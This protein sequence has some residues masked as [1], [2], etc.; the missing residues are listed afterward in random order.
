MKPR[1]LIFENNQI[2]RSTIREILDKR[3]YEVFTFTDADVCPLHHSIEHKCIFEGTCSDIIISDLYM[4]TIEGL[5]SIKEQIDNGCKVKCRALM[6]A[7]WSDEEWQFAQ[8]IGCRL[9]EKPFDV[10]EFLKWIDTCVSRV[11]PGR[12]LFNWSHKDV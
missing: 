12:K 7:D 2:I 10:G 6:S 9:F 11:S 8:K 1:V 3:G 4:P 5:K